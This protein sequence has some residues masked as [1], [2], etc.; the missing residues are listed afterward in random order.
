MLSK[1]SFI[2]Y[3]KDPALSSETKRTFQQICRVHQ[4][5][6]SR[7][8]QEIA[9]AVA[10]KMALVE[11]APAMFNNRMRAEAQALITKL[12]DLDVL[13]TG[14]TTMSALETLLRDDFKIELSS[15]FG[16]SEASIEASIVKYHK[17]VQQMDVKFQVLIPLSDLEKA[18]K[19]AVNRWISFR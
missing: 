6:D 3:P 14:M 1:S 5:D 11:T 4:R 12:Q 13:R 15:L 7:L 18:L 19:Q 2:V 9:D 16:E 17:T 8:I 10:E